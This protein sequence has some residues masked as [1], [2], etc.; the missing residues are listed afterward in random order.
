AAALRVDAARSR[1]RARRRPGA[2]RDPRAGGAKEAGPQLPVQTM[3]P[4]PATCAP[5]AAMTDVGLVLE[6]T[7]PYVPGGVSAWV[8]E[9]I[10]SLPERRF[11]IVHISPER[12]TYRKRRYRLPSNVEELSD[13]YCR[14]SLPQDRDLAVLRRAVRWERWRLRRT[15]PGSR[16][17]GALRRLHLEDTV[18]G[19][20]IDD[21]AS[22]DLTVGAFL[23][24]DD[25]FQLIV[26][27]Y[28]RLA[29]EAPFVDF[30]W[31]F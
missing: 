23:H 1:S 11:V 28:Q 2:R 26:E 10:R 7:Y 4:V 16:V 5:S 21:L 18:D 19:A 9:L 8:H 6:G 29:P 14:E 31:H 20:L 15:R 22:A 12:G 3:T 30:F 25:A 17:L 13:L 27:L 24:G